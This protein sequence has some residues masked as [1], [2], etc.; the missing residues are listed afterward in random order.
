MHPNGDKCAPAKGDV[1][2]NLVQNPRSPARPICRIRGGKD[3]A[4]LP[5]LDTPDHREGSIALSGCPECDRVRAQIA[6]DPVGR[7]GRSQKHSSASRH[8]L[9]GPECDSKQVIG[10]NGVRTRPGNPIGRGEDFASADSYKNSVPLRNAAILDRG[11]GVRDNPCGSI[12]GCQYQSAFTHGDKSPVRVRDRRQQSRRP[13]LSGSPDSAVGRS[14]N[15]CVVESV[16][17]ADRYESPGAIG[18]AIQ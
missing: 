14:K 2:V 1:V 18:N 5:W 3:G 17:A 8:K 11:A 15:G 12:S 13:G 10:S 9:T 7:I 6:C 16:A 4:G